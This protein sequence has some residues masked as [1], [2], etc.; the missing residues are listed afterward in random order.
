MLLLSTL[1]IL[2]TTG[3]K[4]S[5]DFEGFL[6][7][8]ATP[9]SANSRLPR[10]HRLAPS[11]TKATFRPARY[12]QQLSTSD[13]VPVFVLAF[14]ILPAFPYGPFPY[15][16]DEFSRGF[17]S[18]LW[19]P[20]NPSS[21][22][23]RLSRHH[24]IGPLS[25]KADLRPVHFVLSPPVFVSLFVFTLACKFVFVVTLPYELFDIPSASSFRGLKGPLWLPATPSSANSRLPQQRHIGLSSATTVFGSVSHYVSSPPVFVPLFVFFFE[26]MC[27]F[28]FSLPYGPLAIP[29]ANFSRG[30]GG[31]LRLPATPSSANFRLPQQRHIGPSWHAA[32]FGS[33]LVFVLLYVFVFVSSL[34]YGL[35]VIPPATFVRGFGGSLWLPATPSLANFRL[36]LQLHIGPSA[37]LSG[38][39]AGCHCL[40]MCLCLV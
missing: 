17:E 13:F 10:Q 21:A 36:S 14:V 1:A 6:L 30:C 23:F 9:S 33:V 39:A 31:S 40:V 8:P 5:R 20:A 16:C 19:I 27:L 11:S 28:A 37:A 24:H 38:V 35:F 7:M 26:F 34:L 3:E 29:L 18:S 25:A 12:R 15:L 32:V 22:N 2:V 4:I